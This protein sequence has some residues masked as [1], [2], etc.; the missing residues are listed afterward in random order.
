MRFARIFVWSRESLTGEAEWTW[1]LR[2]AAGD[3]LVSCARAF[4]TSRAAAADALDI[5]G[6]SFAGT[7]VH[8]ARPTPTERKPTGRS[9]AETVQSRAE[10]GKLPIRRPLKREAID[11]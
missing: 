8:Y 5:L 4:P 11:R 6:G 9:R 7:L 3:E 1:L 10:P 2:D